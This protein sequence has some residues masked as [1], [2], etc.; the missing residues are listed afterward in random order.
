[1]K[2]LSLRTKFTLALLV[3]G[4]SSALLVGLVARIILL[5][6]FN[7]IELAQ[8]FQRFQANV[9]DYI[10]TY[11]SWDD[12]VRAEDFG[13]FARRRNRA[14]GP[15]GNDGGALPPPGVAPPRFLM[16]PGGRPGVPPDGGRPG[17]PGGPPPGGPPRPGG[18]GPQGAPGGPFRFLLLEE[19]TDRVLIGPEEFRAGAPI[20]DEMRESAMPIQVDGR[21]VA[22]AIPFGQPNLT[23]FDLSYLSAMQNAMLYG[24]GAAALLAVVL[25]F[26]IGAR[27]SR[28]LRRVTTAIAGIS[29]GQLYQ[30]LDEGPA[31]EIGAMAAVFNQ[32]SKEMW[33]SRQRIERQTVMLRE[34]SVRDELTGLHNRRHFDEQAATAFAHA[35]RYHRPLTAMMCDIDHFKAINDRF[36][37]VVGDAVLRAV[38]GILK[39]ET[40]SSDIVARYG[41]EE[42]AVVFTEGRAA[43]AMAFAERIRARVEAYSWR[44]ISPDLQVTISIGLDGSPARTSVADML[45]AADQRL[46][47]AKHAG[48][49]RVVAA[50]APN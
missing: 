28:R 22:R 24:V 21:V 2:A 25:G 26:G 12:A 6:R 4:L 36:T 31:D 49:N 3:V 35:R 5:Q 34:L 39:A 40:R 32:M 27:L 47:E 33:E 18:P 46:Y 15:P 7:Q 30:H 10:Q 41:G 44:E 43:E 20:P 11:G 14:L 17:R 29:N 16:P 45:A 23:P 48:R 1:V 38:A 37:H 42:F 19:G 50:P 9:V 13:V 8:S